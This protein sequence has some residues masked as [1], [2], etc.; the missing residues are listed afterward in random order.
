MTLQTD[1]FELWPWDFAFSRLGD[2]YAFYSASG[3]L[4]VAKAPY[5]SSA[6]KLPDRPSPRD[7]S[8]AVTMAA[9][10]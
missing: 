1:M 2:R 3:L 7:D 9:S 6:R 10:R 4:G 8:I 5:P